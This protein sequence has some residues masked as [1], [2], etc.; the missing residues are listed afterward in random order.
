MKLAAKHREQHVQLREPPAEGGEFTLQRLHG[1]GPGRPQT[2]FKR[3]ASRRAIPNLTLK[4]RDID[5]F[6]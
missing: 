6:F 5:G 1:F 2:S 3:A 4:A